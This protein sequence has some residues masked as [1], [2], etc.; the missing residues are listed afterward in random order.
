MLAI[1]RTVRKS[2]CDTVATSSTPSV[3][4]ACSATPAW[5][6]R[7][8]EMARAPAP[9]HRATGDPTP[10]H[11]LG[12]SHHM[13]DA[14]AHP[15]ALVDKHVRQIVGKAK[16]PPGDSLEGQWRPPDIGEQHRRSAA[17]P[18]LR[19]TVSHRLRWWTAHKGRPTHTP[20]VAVFARSGCKPPD[21]LR[22][23]P[24]TPRDSSHSGL[25]STDCLTL[26]HHSN[27]KRKEVR[28]G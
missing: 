23:R 3:A 11:P 7:R 8:C 22:R 18:R 9:Q 16:R 20:R 28:N 10:D 17:D 26:Q 15:S 14:T 27:F 6:E 25:S 2:C 5:S 19:R 24:P 1:A 4:S 13:S 12:S 21:L